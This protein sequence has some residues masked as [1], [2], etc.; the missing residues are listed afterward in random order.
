MYHKSK[1]R[2]NHI[3]RRQLNEKTKDTYFFLGLFDCAQ[4]V[5]KQRADNE[6]ENE[7]AMRG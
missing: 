3:L 4:K 6:K 5:N 7:T 1:R 2:E